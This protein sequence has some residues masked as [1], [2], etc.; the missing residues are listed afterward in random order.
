MKPPQKLS[1]YCKKGVKN[2]LDY[3]TKPVSR[4]RLR[5]YAI[6]FRELFKVP[7]GEPFPVLDA[8]EKLPD[9]FEGSNY[10]VVADE[11]LPKNV[12]AQCVKND[13]KGFTIEIKQYVYD[14]AMNRIGAYLGFILHEIV[15]IFM[16]E[17]GYTPVLQRSFEETPIY[18]SVEWQVK[19]LTGEIAMPYEETEGMSVSEIMKK[20][21][22]SKG[23]AKKRQRY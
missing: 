18:C 12:V 6:F 19:A 10:I 11:D 23:F 21:N 8:L 20:Y 16:F 4:E 14:G 15:H 22:V 7:A 17:I 1:N 9:F 5:Q 13:G 2:K 3:I